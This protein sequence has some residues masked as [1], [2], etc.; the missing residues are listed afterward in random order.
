MNH[1]IQARVW[2]VGDNIDTDLILPIDVL[3]RPRSER[4]RH[5]FRANRPGWVSQVQPGD[6]LIGG[7]NFGMG[8]GRPAAQ[9]MK[10][11]GLSCVVADTLNGLFF[12]NS[13]NFAFPALEIPGVRDAFEEGDEARVDWMNATITNLRTG[14]TLTG[15]RWPDLMQQCMSAGGLVEQLEAAGMLHP[16]GWSPAPL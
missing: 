11:L 10:D 3:Q 4:P 6:I 16:L 7:R 9:A 12:R 15:E 8:S 14:V 1:I 2:C 13:I 5:M